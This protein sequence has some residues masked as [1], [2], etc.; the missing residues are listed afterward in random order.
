M[1]ENAFRRY[2]LG[3]WVQLDGAWPPDGAWARCADPS[4]SIPGGAEVVLGFDG[5]FLG[6][7]TALLA[8]TVADRPHVRLV[9]LWEAPE[10]SREWR[11][12]L[13][14]VEDAIW[15]ACAR[16]RVLEVAADPYRWQR[17]L[18]LLDAEGI[19]VSEFPRHLPGWGRRAPGSTPPSST[20]C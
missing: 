15:A 3:Q 4:A 18:E 2:R 17:S 9:E 6:D 10:G 20:G 8:C 11:V 1:R 19:A 14:E 5:S 12:P 13:V 16:W 7:C